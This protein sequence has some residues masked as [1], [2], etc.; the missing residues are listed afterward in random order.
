MKRGRPFE[1]G[2]KFGRGR[3]RGSRNKK[4][5]LIQGLLE[6]HAAALMRKSLLLALQGDTQLL[7]LILDHLLLRPQDSPVKMG[8]LPMNTTEELLESHETVMKKLASGALT[9]MQARKSAANSSRHKIWSGESPPSK[10]SRVNRRAAP[11]R[12]YR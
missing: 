6:E 11:N 9:P 5:L 10:R 8:R 3:P 4:T 1:L 2:N 7:R 12:N